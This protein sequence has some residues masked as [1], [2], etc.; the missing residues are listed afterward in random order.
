MCLTGGLFAGSIMAGRIGAGLRLPALAAAIFVFAVTILGVGFSTALAP[1][2]VAI[3]LSGV[4]NAVYAVM[5]QT[6]LLAA[7]DRSQAHGTVMAARFA[8]NQAGKALG[9]ATGAAVTAIA[10]ARGGF[11]VIGAG[12]LAVAATYTLHLLQARAAALGQSSR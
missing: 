12:L 11:T 8:I 3:S 1:A 6:A 2:A 5:N 9:L 4:G 10:G 7:A